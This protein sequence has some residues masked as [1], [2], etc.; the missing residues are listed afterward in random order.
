[1]LLMGC[2]KSISSAPEVASDTVAVLHAAL[3]YLADIDSLILLERRLLPADSLNVMSPYSELHSELPV[4]KLLSAVSS[5]FPGVS[6]FDPGPAPPDSATI[7]SLSQVTTSGK[8]AF[9]F[10]VQSSFDPRW[11][12]SAHFRRLRLEYSDTAGWKVVDA[13][14]TGYEN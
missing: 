6:L 14:V 11:G 2:D 5:Q 3:K 4:S 13:R 7:L 9:V 12:Y 10:A 8:Q 1:M